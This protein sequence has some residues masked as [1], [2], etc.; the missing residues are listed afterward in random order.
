MRLDFGQRVFFKIQ[1]HFF[2][3][4][5]S[6]PKPVPLPPENLFSHTFP[7]TIWRILPHP[8][9]D[10]WVVELRDATRK[11]VSWALV[12]LPLKRILWQQSPP[13]T[14]WWTTLAGFAGN[15]IF[16]HNYLFPD[17]PEATD[18]LALSSAKGELEWA[19]PGCVFV[20][21]FPDFEQ[22]IV[23]QKQGEII[24]YRLCD[25]NLGL[26][27]NQ[28]LEKDLPPVVAPNYRT[29]VRYETQDI[30]FDRLSSFLDKIVGVTGTIAVDYLE[31]DPYLVISYYLYESKKTAQYLLVVN[32]DKQIIYHN[33]LS[34]NR[35][36]MSLDTILF[37]KDRLVF[38]RNT[39]ELIS[40][41]LTR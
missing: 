32:R 21:D 38:L 28:I 20:R 34:D 5:I 30:Y 16:L 1:R 41:I 27:K 7:E 11:T 18:L 36:G 23:A 12:D 25:S 40:L 3:T 17:I 24:Q 14:D 6:E 13:A 8:D 33:Q 37:K 15:R 9:R 29:P 4:T 2:K 31:S 10:Q 19:L 35:P 39:H 22:I 26:L